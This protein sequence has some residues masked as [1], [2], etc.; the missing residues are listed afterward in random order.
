MEAFLAANRPW[1]HLLARG[2]AI[3]R[4]IVPGEAFAFDGLE[5][6]PF[7]SPHRAEDTDT[8]GLDVRG[9]RRRVVYLPDADLFPDEIVARV[10]AADVAL[11]DGTFFDRTELPGRD[12]S[13]IPHPFVVESVERLAAARGRVLFTHLNHSNALLWPDEASRPLLPAPFGVAE[14][15]TRVE[16]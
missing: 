1:S 4:R 8:V 2:E 15:G 6:V 9:P 13:Q 3:V 14:E 10:V 7:A 5:V 12:L 11:V 16:L